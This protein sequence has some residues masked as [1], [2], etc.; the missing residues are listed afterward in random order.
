[1]SSI[2]KIARNSW[3][4][5]YSL[6]RALSSLSN[7]V[8]L[9]TLFPNSKFIANH[10]TSLDG[11]IYALLYTLFVSICPYMFEFLA[12]WGSNA[13]SLGWAGKHNLQF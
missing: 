4:T 3:F 2:G 7:G 13:S 8:D 9:V 11:L 5:S 6:Y 10:N 1:M 12:C